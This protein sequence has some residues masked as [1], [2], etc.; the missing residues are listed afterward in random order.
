MIQPIGYRIDQRNNSRVSFSGLGNYQFYGKVLYNGKEKVT[1]IF[2]FPLK[3]K[4][5]LFMDYK[6]GLLRRAGLTVDGKTSVKKYQYTADNKLINVQKDG[7]DVFTKDCGYV[8]SDAISYYD[9]INNGAIELGYDSAGKKIAAV[10]KPKL[11][12]SIFNYIDNTI[13]EMRYKIT[14]VEVIDGD[15][16]RIYPGESGNYE[17]ESKFSKRLSKNL[18]NGHVTVTTYDHNNTAT[19][20]EK[21]KAGNIVST[22]KTQFNKLEKPIWSVETDANGVM[23]FEKYTSYDPAGNKINDKIYCKSEG[24]F[25]K[26]HTYDI[27]GNIIQTKITDLE[28]NVY[29]TVQNTYNQDGK[30]LNTK[31]IGA[32]GN[33]FEKEEYIYDKKGNLAESHYIGSGSELYDL[34]EGHYYY[35]KEKLVKEIEHYI[36][37]VEESYYNK[38]GKLEKFVVKDL[39]TKTEY[40]YLHKYNRNGKLL[41]TTKVDGNGNVIFTMDHSFKTTGIGEAHTKIYKNPNGEFVIKEV[42]ITTENGTKSIYQDAEG[43]IIDPTPYLEYIYV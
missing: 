33:I 40:A 26:D 4:K 41:N 21:D 37:S 19:V 22:I 5:M 6:D 27:D 25:I 30:L 9:S 15:S 23:V 11:I 31:N 29:S 38:S 17:I 20:I 2:M 43:H 13:N 7:Y 24:D 12:K 14:N 35:A 18:Q 10:I 39:K 1:Q 16:W 8:D 28:G 3:S 34:Q 32:N 42:I 36:G